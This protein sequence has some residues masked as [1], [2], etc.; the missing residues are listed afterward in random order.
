[1]R[2]FINAFLC[3]S[4]SIEPI[5]EFCNAKD[6]LYFLVNR[7]FFNKSIFNRIYQ[8]SPP[9]FRWPAKTWGG[10]LVDTVKNGFVEEETIDE[11][12]KRILSVAKFNDR[13]NRKR[14]AEKS[15]DKKS[16]RELIKKTATEGMV[17][18]KNEE[19]LPF[20]KTKISKIALI[21]R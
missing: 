10:N 9:S 21:G 8:V 12:V 19:V 2:L 16:H 5:V 13:F 7:F 11:K 20:D 17:L 18:L 3:N 14:V 4:F 6:S 1:M 15:I